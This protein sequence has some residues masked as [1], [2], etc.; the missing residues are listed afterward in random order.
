MPYVN[1]LHRLCDIWALTLGLKD[2]VNWIS[3]DD[4]TNYPLLLSIYIET[5]SR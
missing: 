1:E 3:S 4:K 5:R 2:N